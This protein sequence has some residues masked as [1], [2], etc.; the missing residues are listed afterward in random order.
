MLKHLGMVYLGQSEKAEVK[1]T[2]NLSIGPSPDLESAIESFGY[3]R[4]ARATVG[5]AEPRALRD[6][7]EQ[8]PMEDEGCATPS[9]AQPE[10]T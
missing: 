3:V 6:I 1:Q 10:T 9:T 7:G 2:T 4:P 8:G 5:Q